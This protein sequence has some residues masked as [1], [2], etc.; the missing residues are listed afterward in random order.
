MNVSK[1]KII[2]SVLITF[3]VCATPALAQVQDI[4]NGLNA[5][6]K[7]AYTTTQTSANQLPQMIGAVI[8]I[9]LQTVGVL[10]LG[11]LVYAGFLWMTAG[12]DETKVK[13]ATTTIRNVIIGLVIVVLAYAIA[14]WVLEQLNC[15]QNG[16]C[17]TDVVQM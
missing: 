2:S 1:I 12:G 5:A 9:V 10:L 15:V 8:G 16:K 7:G 4:G 17:P 3:A 6:A 14:G 13:A 11:Y